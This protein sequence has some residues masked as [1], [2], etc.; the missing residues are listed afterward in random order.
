MQMGHS[1]IQ[2]SE[3]EN[4][5]RDANSSATTELQ[6]RGTKQAL[7]IEKSRSNIYSVMHAQLPPSEI[8]PSFE[9]QS[10]QKLPLYLLL[11]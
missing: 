11:V 4:L 9:L 7:K 5:A 2:K 3:S 8:N 6:C 1:P 10:G